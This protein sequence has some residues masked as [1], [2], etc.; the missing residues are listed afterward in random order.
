MNHEI[1]AVYRVYVTCSLYK[2]MVQGYRVC[3]ELRA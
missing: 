1:Q 2:D 3:T